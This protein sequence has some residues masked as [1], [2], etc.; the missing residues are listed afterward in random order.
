MGRTTEL[1]TVPKHL[2][3]RAEVTGPASLSKRSGTV[4][5]ILRSIKPDQGPFKG[6]I[7]SKNSSPGIA[8]EEIS[9]FINLTN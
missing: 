5:A 7:F 1:G 9:D 3:Q 6:A 8:A 4:Q 2:H